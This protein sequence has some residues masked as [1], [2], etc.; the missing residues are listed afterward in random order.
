LTPRLSVVI[1]NWNAGG[2]LAESVASVYASDLPDAPEVVVV[3]NHSTDGSLRRLAEDFPAVRVI[4]N[5]ENRGFARA[6]NQGILA[7]AGEYVL[8]LNPD[9]FLA[10]DTLR[11]MADFLDATPDAGA[12]APALVDGEGRRVPLGAPP[13]LARTLLSDTVAARLFPALL[14]SPISFP[15]TVTRT[16]I[17]SGSCMLL[18][19]TALREA[20]L[21][22]ERLF[23]YFEEAD[24]L[25]RFHR[26]GWRAYYLPHVSAV[27]LGE[28]STALLPHSEK[29]LIYKQSALQLWR[30]R[31]GPWGGLALRALQFPLVLLT[32]L[33]VSLRSL[34]RPREADAAQ[35]RFHL[36]FLRLIL[37]LWRRSG[38]SG[39]PSRE[40]AHPA[41]PSPPSA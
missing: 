22:N 36:A 15:T 14:E 11:A 37:G 40:G 6:N 26:R 33:L 41:P 39:G 21:V 5:E 3:D 28:R 38:A 16:R 13:G 9:A 17:L 8:Q 20:G 7:T 29:L 31:Y 23:L 34:V 24:L 18:R 2:L 30:S 1:V 19:R 10:P 35:I 12:V 4:Q 27:H 32:L 25:E